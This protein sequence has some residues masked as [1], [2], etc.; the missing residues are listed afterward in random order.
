MLVLVISA[1]V[2]RRRGTGPARTSQLDNLLQIFDLL[3]GLAEQFFKPINLSGLADYLMDYRRDAPGPVGYVQISLN[4]AK[5]IDTSF[6]R[7]NELKNK[8]K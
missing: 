2:L 7:L 8:K 5:S 1:L 4:G 3:Q 6:I